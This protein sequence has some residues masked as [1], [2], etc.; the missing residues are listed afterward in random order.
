[1]FPVS[2]PIPAILAV[3]LATLVTCPQRGLTPG[4]RRKPEATHVVLQSTNPIPER[5][6]RL[7]AIPEMTGLEGYTRED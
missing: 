1:M 4:F 2:A 6:K 5:Q 3:V 7:S